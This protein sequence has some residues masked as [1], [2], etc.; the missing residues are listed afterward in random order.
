MILELLFPFTFKSNHDFSASRKCFCA[1]LTSLTVNLHRQDLC[2]IVPCSHR[3]ILEGGIVLVCGIN[4]CKPEIS[5]NKKVCD[6]GSEDEWDGLVN[7]A[8]LD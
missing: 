5:V 1:Y 2:L 7:K 4:V 6:Y 8:F 3:A